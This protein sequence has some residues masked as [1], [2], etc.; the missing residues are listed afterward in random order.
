MD[1]DVGLAEKTSKSVL[2]VVR[3]GETL[4]P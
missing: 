2:I 4:S 3:E 1:I